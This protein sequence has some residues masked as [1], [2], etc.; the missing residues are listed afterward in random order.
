M[1][2]RRKV[3]DVG[4]FDQ[5]NMPEVI[6]A[7]PL[8]CMVN[9]GL[10][11]LDMPIHMPGVGW[12]VPPRLARYERMIQM[13]KD[14]EAMFESGVGGSTGWSAL[15]VYITVDQKFVPASTYGRRPGPHSDAY[16]DVALMLSPMTTPVA[17]TYICMDCVPTEFY[18]ATTFGLGRATSCVDSLKSFE[19][20]A[21]RA[22]ATRTF[23]PGTLL[24]LDPFVVHR[25]A[26]APEDVQRT[27]VKISFS[28]KR[29][30]RQGN[31]H[32]P[33]FAYDWVM[34]P[35]DPTRNHPYHLE[36]E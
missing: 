34:K 2:C 19:R 3:W 9:Q 7:V 17:H 30:N 12:R 33:L 11:F 8:A 23:P 15:Y 26:L 32:N 18:P 35:R 6:G 27:F 21:A 1:R 25:A 29:Y 31:T 20:T 16:E 36:L 22:A 13:A 28:E 5:V 14:R 10:R 4:H 24:R